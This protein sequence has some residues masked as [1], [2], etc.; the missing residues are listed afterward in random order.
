[1]ENRDVEDQN[2]AIC[3]DDNGV[4]MFANRRG[5]LTYDGQSEDLIR[6]PVIPYTL[7]YN[8]RYK[9]VYV[10]GVDNYGYISYGYISRDEMGRYGY[11]SM[12]EDSTSTGIITKIVFS[13]TSVYFYSE[14]SISRHNISSGNLEERYFYRS[15]RLFTGMFVTRTE[16]YVNIYS[17]GLY[18]IERDS[19]VPVVQGYLVAN[20]NILFSL[21][22]DDKLV[23]L[24][25]SSSRLLLFDGFKFLWWDKLKDEGYLKLN[26]L[27]EGLA[28]ADSLYAFSTLG[29]G[30]MVV[31]K[32]TGRPT[33]TINY[34]TGLPDDEI[35]ALGAD[36]ANGLWMSHQ[37]GI[38]RADL[39]LPVGNFSSYPGLE[40]NLVSS[41]YHNNVLYVATSEGVFYLAEKPDYTVEKIAVR[42][43]R[44][45]EKTLQ[46]AQLNPQ[47]RQP[48]PEASRTK[49]GG[50]L[51]FFGKKET[52]Q[53]GA[54]V[55]ENVE[56]QK[57]V[58]VTRPPEQINR[59]EISFKQIRNIKSIA[60]EYKKVQGLNEKCKQIVA[61]GKELLAST[62]RGLYVIKDSTAKAIISDKSVNYVSNISSDGR[63]WVALSDGFMYLTVNNGTWRSFNPYPLFTRP[64]YSITGADEGIVWAGSD[65]VAYRISLPDGSQKP[66]YKAYRLQ[67]EYPQRFNVDYVND[68]VFIFSE[69]GVSYYDPLS[70]GMQRYRDDIMREENISYIS[71]Q[72][73]APW[74]RIGN[75]WIYLK[76]DD[77]ISVYDRSALNIV[78]NIRS[79][80]T[81]DRFI[82]VINAENQL[83]R[84]VRD[85]IYGYKPDFDLYIKSIR[86][87]EN[88]PFRLSDIE[89]GRGE[90]S[91]IFELIAPDYLKKNSMQYQH[92]VDKVTGDWSKWDTNPSFI[93]EIKP[94]TTTLYYRAQDI[95]GNISEPRSVTFTSKR[96]FTKTSFFYVLISIVF[97]SVIIVIVWFRERQLQ[98]EKRVLEM[99]VSERTAK[100]EAQKQE[101]TSSIEY[102]GRIQMAMLPTDEHCSE[103][104]NDYFILFR[105]RDIVSGDFYWIGEDQDHVFFTVA[106][107]TGHGVPGA[108]MS[109]LGI[110][111][112]YEIITNKKKLHANIV[113]NLLREKIKNSLHQTGKVGEA[114]DGMDIAF[115]ILHKDKS[116]L[117]FAGAFIPLVIVQ[118]NEIKEYKGDRMPI[119]IYYG[120]KDSF[121]NYEI[122]IH[123][124]DAIYLFS[125]GYSDQFGGPET[126]KY[127]KATLKKLLLDIHSLPMNRQKD[128]I[129][130]EFEKWKGNNQQIDDITI[131]G[132]RV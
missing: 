56:P 60:Y 100:I 10:G 25:L 43:V 49:K 31:D 105:P 74:L 12:S 36:R 18:K 101:I 125:D 6:I 7:N 24:G 116:L 22:Y 26:I 123:S 93:M 37:G 13:E 119:G 96:P 34:R 122:N 23:L 95:W 89:F 70:D 126:T 66:A 114:A 17:E 121:T 115:C 45:I 35:F 52:S 68:T 1:M 5:I 129:E 42:N 15:N 48:V 90:N 99:K 106:D 29:G 102:A 47:L 124:G 97:L 127:K 117:E 41:L 76:N 59:S 92:V 58:P 32:S 72:P 69:T 73:D 46:P 104:F 55:V 88:E 53:T 86:N 98:N 4:M 87:D 111:T 120:E 107:C 30:V 84:L 54:A 65:N 71:S 78:D 128:M 63:Y 2:W 64:L 20:D 80:S 113:L 40:G 62:V 14:Q 21:P 79:I 28:L 132:I 61:A 77:I 9:K 109:T 81:D 51:R 11:H 67:N 82:W 33:L 94:G 8:Q 57:P 44:K 110:S 75:E 3:Q 103:L 91:I 112:L 16:A 108:F 83:F 39:L 118:E 131:F 130:A 27:S 50:I 85:Q 38:T 19:L